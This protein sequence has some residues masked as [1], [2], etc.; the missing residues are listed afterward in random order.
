MWHGQSWDL[1]LSN[2]AEIVF[3]AAMVPVLLSVNHERDG[4]GRTYGRTATMAIGGK[5]PLVAF[6]LKSICQERSVKSAVLVA[7]PAIVEN[8]IPLL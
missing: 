6:P 7:L 2:A 8:L 3:L 4:H 5:Q 1:T